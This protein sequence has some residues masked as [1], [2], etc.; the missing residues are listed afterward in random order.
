MS[1][2]VRIVF[3]IIQQTALDTELPRWHSVVTLTC[4]QNMYYVGR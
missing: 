4:K 2:F 3:G 1:Y